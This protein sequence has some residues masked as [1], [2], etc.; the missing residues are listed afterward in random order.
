MAIENVE[1]DRKD[2]LRYKAAH[3]WELPLFF[4]IGEMENVIFAFSSQIKIR[5]IIM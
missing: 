3:C 4:A 5:Y 1:R 2:N